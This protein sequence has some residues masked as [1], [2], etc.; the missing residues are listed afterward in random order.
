MKKQSL[1][2][3]LIVFCFFLSSCAQP[4]YLL[5]ERFHTEDPLP[6]FDM[7]N[8]FRGYRPVCESQ[9]AIYSQPMDSAFL[10]YYDKQSKTCG[11]YA[12]SRTVPIRTAAVTP[13]RK[14]CGG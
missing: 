6:Q 12:A 1:L 5:D 13:M 3:L 10:W 2:Y 14:A 7:Q 8:Q 4:D 9:E 11:F